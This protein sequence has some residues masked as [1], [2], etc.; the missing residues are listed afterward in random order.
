MQFLNKCTLMQLQ[1]KS[2][3]RTKACWTAQCNKEIDGRDVE[4]IFWTPETD[5]SLEPEHKH[6][7]KWPLT[8][9]YE[10]PDP[11]RTGRVPKWSL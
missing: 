2:R 3:M 7:P 1:N 6:G 5:S 11:E 9:V 8:M 4:Q 10:F